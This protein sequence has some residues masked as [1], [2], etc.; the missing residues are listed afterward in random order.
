[1]IILYIMFRLK[2]TSEQRE[3]NNA[4][5]KAE[6]EAAA[7]KAAEEAAANWLLVVR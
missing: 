1:M 4:R 5:L 2:R 3:K 7:K 6:A